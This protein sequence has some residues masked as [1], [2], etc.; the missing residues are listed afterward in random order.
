VERDQVYYSDASVQERKDR[1]AAK[2]G[3]LRAAATERTEEA[4]RVAEANRRSKE[5]PG[6]RSVGPTGRA[7]RNC[8]YG[9]ALFPQVRGLA[10]PLPGPRDGDLWSLATSAVPPSCLSAATDSR[11]VPSQGLPAS[12][13]ACGGPYTD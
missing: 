11:S 6:N 5:R 4:E 13:S 9:V 7:P 3:H 12:C 1:R 2:Y 8:R 10:S